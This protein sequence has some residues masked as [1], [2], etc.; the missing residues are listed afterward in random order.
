MD[1]A[2][3]EYANRKYYVEFL[4]TSQYDDGNILEDSIYVRLTSKIF[5]AALHTCAIVQ[6][7]ISAP[8]R[9]ISNADKMAHI[10]HLGI[11][12]YMDQLEQFLLKVVDEDD[13]TDPPGNN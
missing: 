11:A 1:A 5:V 3:I 8:F 13:F 2:F 9:F 12:K 10:N 6:H 4:E 7:K